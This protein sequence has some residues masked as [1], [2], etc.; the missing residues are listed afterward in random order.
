M[1]F[2]LRILLN[3]VLGLSNAFLYQV[4]AMYIVNPTG[5]W[6]E[7]SESRPEEFITI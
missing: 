3:V 2:C 5:K 7:S 1:L 6:D 4:I